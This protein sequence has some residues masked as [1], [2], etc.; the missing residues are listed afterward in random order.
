MPNAAAAS[1]GINRRDVGKDWPVKTTSRD[2]GDHLYRN[3]NGKFIEA[4][5]RCIRGTS[6]VWSGASAGGYCYDGYPDEYVSND[7]YERDYLYIN[8]K[9]RKNMTNLNN[10]SKQPPLLLWATS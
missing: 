6:R 5:K 1:Q 7:S 9:K 2:G 8:Q 4:S 10:T 3:D